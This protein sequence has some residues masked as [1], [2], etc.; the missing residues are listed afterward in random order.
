MSHHVALLAQL[1]PLS[2]LSGLVLVGCGKEVGRLPFSHEATQSAAV[3]LVAGKIDFWTDI[4]VSYE[5]PAALTYQIELQ[6]GGQRVA[7][8]ACEA[9]GHH[10]RKIGWVETGFGYSRSLRGSGRMICS[11]QLLKAG[12]TD[13]RAALQFTTRPRVATLVRADL[14]I[15]Q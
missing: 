13:V 10:D 4:S 8:V 5:G 12:L 14:V 7:N 6:Q 15:K 3:P 9:L 2:L 1:L 11:A